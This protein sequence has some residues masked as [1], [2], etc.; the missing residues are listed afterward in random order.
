[1]I[2]AVVKYENNSN[3]V[4]CSSKY[5]DVKIDLSNKEPSDNV[6][7]YEPLPFILDR[8]LNLLDE[9]KPAIVVLD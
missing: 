4:C 9:V 2:K 5:G 7:S 6:N 3:Y 8:R 1:M